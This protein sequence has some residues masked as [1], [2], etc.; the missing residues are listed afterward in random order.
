MLGPSKI[1]V[2]PSRN[3]VPVYPSHLPTTPPPT[4][5]SSPSLGVRRVSSPATHE[6]RSGGSTPRARTRRPSE[7]VDGQAQKMHQ[8]NLFGTPPGSG[9]TMALP[10]TPSTSGETDVFTSPKGS[11]SGAGLA[12]RPADRRRPSGTLPEDISDQLSPG[13]SLLPRRISSDHDRAATSPPPRRPSQPH[14][15]TS[16]PRRNVTPGRARKPPARSPHP[17]SQ[18]DLEADTEAGDNSSIQSGHPSASSSKAGTPVMDMDGDGFPLPNGYNPNQTYSQNHIYGQGSSRLPVPK[19]SSSS[20][21]PGS[22]RRGSSTSAHQSLNE[23]SRP[24][25]SRSDM[26][27]SSSR[28]SDKEKDRDRP[29]R[30]R[31]ATPSAAGSPSSRSIRA[32]SEREVP[33]L[34]GKKLDYK[35]PSSS[36]SPYGSPRGSTDNLPGLHGYGN[37]LGQGN[38]PGGSRLPLLGP[39]LGTRRA[40]EGRKMSSGGA[41]GENMGRERLGGMGELIHPDASRSGSAMPSSSVEAYFGMWVC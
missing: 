29:T 18:S 1:P 2:S 26:S 11:G 36:A 27:Q 34:P 23:H 8:Q 9:A 7:M 25:S 35:S 19:S 12:R 32:G 3:R 15:D 21:R 10:I 16:F 30:S 5:G 41:E 39:V 14:I 40:S 24:G 28:P 31:P 20:S 6:L 37:G 4:S 17:H 22:S 13:R 38:T 33:P